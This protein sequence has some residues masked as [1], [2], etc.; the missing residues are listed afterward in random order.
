MP[1]NAFQSDTGAR[2]AGSQ[3]V[4]LRDGSNARP[5]AH[6]QHVLQQL[7]TRV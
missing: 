5:D 1:Y 6:I 3:T 2:L 4:R 7:H